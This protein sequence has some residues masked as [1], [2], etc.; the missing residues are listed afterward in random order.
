MPYFEYDGEVEVDVDYF[1]SSCNSS[2]IKEIIQ[3]LVNDGYLPKSVLGIENG[4]NSNGVAE[5]EFEDA[6]DKLHGKWNVLS[7]EEEEAIIKIS[8]R[9]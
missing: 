2:E 1:L 3:A 7:R 4:N 9:F 6:L 8:K 5:L